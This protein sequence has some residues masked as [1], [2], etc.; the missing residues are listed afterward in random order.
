MEIN[1]DGFHVWMIMRYAI[2]VLIL[3]PPSAFQ[4]A[5]IVHGPSWTQDSQTLYSLHGGFRS[6]CSLAPLVQIR[7]QT[8]PKKPCGQRSQR[9]QA[10]V[11][12]ALGCLC[13]HHAFPQYS[14][15]HLHTPFASIT[16][17]RE[18][19]S[20][21]ID[22]QSPL[23]LIGSITAIPSP[24]AAHEKRPLPTSR[25]PHCTSRLRRGVHL[26][27][28]HPSRPFRLD[29]KHCISRPHP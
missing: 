20:N 18:G 8:R 25:P 16:P 19:S 11:E 9:V 27:N 17:R 4:S 3:L 13:Q 24:L 23:E 22:H 2:D 12:R 14:T 7:P 5:A 15:S 26:H 21:H 10:R 29:H 6:Q 28:L 1:I